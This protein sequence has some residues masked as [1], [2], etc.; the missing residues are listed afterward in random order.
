VPRQDARSLIRTAA[1]AALLAL[2]VAACGS[3]GGDAAVTATTTVTTTVTAAPTTVAVATTLAGP[4][5]DTFEDPG[6]EYSIV[7]G[8]DWSDRTSEAGSGAIE[9][10]Q[11]A[12]AANGFASNVNVVTERT[13]GM[14]LDPYI[15]ASIKN[16]GTLT[17]LSTEVV[18]GPDGRDR[19]VVEYE[20]TVEGA[21]RPLHFLAVIDVSDERAAIATFT[22]EEAA[23]AGLRTEVEPYMMTITAV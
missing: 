5:G 8:P 11:V 12:P 16:L 7:T 22:A 14:E 19:G 18:T 15:E 20:G 9:L 1:A 6:G 4:A 23:F 21:D 2:A 17:V 3:T 13:G 10:W